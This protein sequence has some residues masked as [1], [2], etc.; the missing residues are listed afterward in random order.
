MDRPIKEEGQTVNKHKKV[1]SPIEAI[2]LLL[3]LAVVAW[4]QTRSVNPLKVERRAPGVVF[5]DLS[6]KSRR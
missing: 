5:L 3:F 6:G 2:H 1:D 4:T